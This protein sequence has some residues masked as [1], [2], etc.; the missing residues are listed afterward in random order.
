MAQTT[1]T[2][3]EIPGYVEEPIKK[4]LGSIEDF[5][6][7]GSNYVYGSK[8]GESLYTPLSGSQ[9]KSIG[10]VNWLAD[11]DLA[12]MFGISDASS[13][14]KDYA[15]DP[16]VRMRGD[17]SGATVDTSKY[18]ETPGT[19]STERL[20]DENGQLGAIS[21]YMNPYLDQVLAPQIRE[22][23]E[24]IQRQRNDLGASSAMSGAFGDARH[25]ILEGEIYRGGNE[26]VGDAAGRTHADAFTQ[27]MGARSGDLNRFLNVDMANM[28]NANRALE[29]MMQG[30]FANL[31]STNQGIAR[32]MQRDFANQGAEEAATSRKAAGAQG[33]AGLG[34]QYFNLFTDVNDMLFNAGEVEREAEM[35]RSEAM[36]GYQEAIKSKKYDD[37]LKL[38]MAAQGA[39]Y[40]TDTTSKTKSNDGLFG[41]LGSA[42]GSIF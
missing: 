41:L 40:S 17:Y 30:D 15:N 29:R 31:D 1:R 32:N 7:S 37:A 11:Q 6:N 24:A 9:Q 35:E 4:S 42:L 36:R 22:I 39:P 8:K 27:A 38:L 25:G 10:N 3:T 5:L 12:K 19:L 18:G 21:D 2:S 13:M 16:A 23:D 33:L 28:D 26:A 34:G 20:V 14:W